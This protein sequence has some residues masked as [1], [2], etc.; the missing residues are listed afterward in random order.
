MT[1]SQ[2]EIY[3]YC[4][5]YLRELKMYKESLPFS[6]QRFGCGSSAPNIE[7]TLDKLNRDMYKEVTRII[8]DTS[9]K[10]QKIIDN[11]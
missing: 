11:A 5:K 4:S 7:H 8:S 3:K 2:V 6:I 10:V 9:Y 1:E